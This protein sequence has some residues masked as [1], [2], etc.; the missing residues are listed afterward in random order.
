[1]KKITLSL[2]LGLIATVISAQI[3][4]FNEILTNQDAP[5]KMQL[6]DNFLYV[7]EDEGQNLRRFDLNGT[8]ITGEIVYS[9]TTS[10]TEPTIIEVP[11]DFL[12]AG[13]T[14]YI[15]KELFNE[16][17][18]TS[19]GSTIFS[20]ENSDSSST[21]EIA[22]TGTGGFISAFDII[23]GTLFYVVDTENTSGDVISEIFKKSLKN[24]SEAATLIDSIDGV[25]ND[26]DHDGGL[27]LV[28]SRESGIVYFDSTN[29]SPSIQNFNFSE[30]LNFSKGIDIQNNRMYIA[31][32]R[33]I[34]SGIIST[35][36]TI[37]L[38]TNLENRFY[39]DEN[40]GSTFF[41]NFTS[42]V[43]N[44]DGIGYA[45]IAN[46]GIIGESF[47]FELS[48]CE[49]ASSTFEEAIT[50]LEAP[51]HI[52]LL[53]TNE[54]VIT[55]ENNISTVN[56][57]DN[58]ITVIY[59]RDSNEFVTDLI[60]D[61]DEVFIASVLG[62]DDGSEDLAFDFSKISRINLTN[63]I[64]DI[65]YSSTDQYIFEIEKIANDLFFIHEPP[66][67]DDS[68]EIS[69]IDKVDLSTFAIEELNIDYD[70]FLNSGFLV[71]NTFY[72]AEDENLYSAPISDLDNLT[73]LSND[74]GFITNMIIQDNFIYYTQGNGAKRTPLNFTNFKNESEF[75]AIN[76]TYTVNEE[77]GST[78]CAS[79]EDLVMLGNTIY[80]SIEGDNPIIS[81]A[82]ETIT[83]STS[84]FIHKATDLVSVY[85]NKNILHINNI[86]TVETVD[87]YDL[88]GKLIKSA[89]IST[90]IPVTDLNTGLYIV[91]INGNY[92]LKFIK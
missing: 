8:P 83:L 30:P 58:A 42:V 48:E 5:G 87:I 38:F 25:V 18:N 10:S 33:S 23:N 26:M 90:E 40:N 85:V 72:I 57:T 70:F 11:N 71:G 39:E 80:A 86:K 17:T 36:G 56:L 59:N 21:T 1:M 24:L 43:V 77:D 63:D 37:E 31:A 4:N 67:F 91:I 88:N 14:T 7:L 29:I 6:V 2:V 44:E 53:N 68:N 89:N 82:N 34:K 81:F 60:V 74:T 22:S 92:S 19:M 65:V 73:L 62:F 69:S 76:A 28:S 75:I 3:E 35:T 61:G 27:V 47:F 49:G 20:F 15:T 55:N 32:G 84:N 16:S 50:S 45:S 9:F 51:L 79:L 78:F 46:E 41:T 52:E 12:I 66:T 13:N 54:L 64:T